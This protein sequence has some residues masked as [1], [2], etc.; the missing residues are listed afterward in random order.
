MNTESQRSARLNMRIS[1]E[2]LYD[3]KFAASINHQDL[4][5]F[6][7]GVALERAREIIA[8]DQIIRLTPREVMQLEKMLEQVDAPNTKLKSLFAR[9]HDR[10]LANSKP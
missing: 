6:V 9:V 7:L 8:E 1:P 3:L 4:S 10:N 5:S 2:A